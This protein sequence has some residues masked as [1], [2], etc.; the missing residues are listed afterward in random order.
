M[1]TSTYVPL[2]NTTLG[3][4]AS[5]VTFS[6]ITSYRDFVIVISAKGTGSGRVDIEFNGDTTRTNYFR[7]IMRGTGSAADSGLYNDNAQQG[8]NTTEFVINNIQVMDASA[9]DKHKCFMYRVSDNTGEIVVGNGRWAN[10]A[11]VTQ[12]RLAA[13][14]CSFATGSTFA[15]Y[16]IAS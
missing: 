1:P 13:V 6:S 12:I 7:I 14:G 16:G 10:T 3:S 9:T 4:S 15:L 8:L 2:A 5:S 11:A